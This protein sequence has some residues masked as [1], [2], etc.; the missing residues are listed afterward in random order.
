MGE[1]VGGAGL[2]M[3]MSRTGQLI[4]V[5]SLSGESGGEAAVSVRVC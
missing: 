1:E 5:M 4:S 3:K 2:K